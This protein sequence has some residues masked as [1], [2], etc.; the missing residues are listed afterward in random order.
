MIFDYETYKV[1]WWCFV[2]VLLLGFAL[3]DGFDFGVGMSLPFLGKDDT[4]R[5]VIINTIGPTWEGTRPGSSLRAAPCLPPGRW[6]MQP[7]SPAFTS[8]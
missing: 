1:I 8:R 7:L 3:T 4:E 2:A 5:R 6:C